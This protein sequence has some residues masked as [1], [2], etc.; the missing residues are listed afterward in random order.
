M[1][2][3]ITQHNPEKCRECGWCSEIVACPGADELICICCGAC[4]LSCPT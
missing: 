1:K 3:Y 4:V 2:T